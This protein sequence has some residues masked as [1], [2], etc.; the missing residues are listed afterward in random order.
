MKKKYK[1]KLQILGAN[2]S[3]FLLNSSGRAIDVLDW[4]DGRDL[5]EKVLEKI[6][7]IVKKNDLAL[8]DT[9]KFAFECDSPYFRKANKLSID[10]LASCDSKGKCG[11]TSWQVGGITIKTLNFIAERK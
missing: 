3:L 5:A 7:F 2:A 10:S 8:K 9:R 11:F 4:T 6:N 1:I